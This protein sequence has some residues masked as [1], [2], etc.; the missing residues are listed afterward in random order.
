[1]PVPNTFDPGFRL[2]DASLVNANFTAL[3]T[4]TVPFTNITL[5]PNGFF[6]ESSAD[7]ITAFAGGGQAGAFALTAETNRVT[8]VA[9]AG[10]SVKLPLSVPG[11][12]IMVIN[13]GAATMQV[14]GAGTDTIDDVGATFGVPQMVNSEVIYTTTLAGKWYSNGLGTGYAGAFP[15]VSF[16]NA[17]TAFAG[18]GQA[19]ATQLTTCINRV[20]VCATAADSVKLPVSAGGLQ[21]TVANAGAASLNAFPSTGDAINGA[22]VNTALAIPVNKTSTF[23]CAVAGQ[24]HAVVS[25]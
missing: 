3:A 5:A 14:F 24:W 13:H 12:T 20:T 2:L 16:Q 1:M 25:A 6:F 23:S 11:L 21:I 15:T 18:G 9:T 10:D 22:A 4:G 19:S 8:V 17:I 7:G